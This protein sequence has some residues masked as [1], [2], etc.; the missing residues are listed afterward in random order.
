MGLAPSE[1][2]KM[3]LWQFHACV[4]QWNA[5][6]SPDGAEK[7]VSLSDQE[8]EEIGRWLDERAGK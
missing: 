8:A 2:D 4:D 1:V 5:H 7:G 3:S 6:N